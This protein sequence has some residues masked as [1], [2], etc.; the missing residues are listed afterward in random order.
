MS[1]GLKYEVGI[2]L[3]EIRNQLAYQKR[4]GFFFGAGSSCSVGISDIESL[5]EKIKSEL[6]SEHKTLF[7]STISTLKD[8]VESFGDNKVNIEDILNHIRL[9]RKITNENEES[10]F[11]KLTGKDAKYLDENICKAIYTII[12]EEEGKASLETPQ[13]FI[14]WLNWFSSDSTKEIFTSNYD[15]IFEKCLETQQVPYFDGFVGSYEPFFIQDSLDSELTSES[16]PKS[17]IRLWKVHGSI[18]WFWKDTNDGK[19]KKVIRRGVDSKD[20]LD[21]QEIVIYP[22]IDKYDSSR[23]QPFVVYLD[24]LKKFLGAGEGVFIISGYSFADQHINEIIFNG[25]RQN[26][27]LHAICFC[28][29]DE[30][31]EL[32]HK[33]SNSILNLT[34]LGPKSA[35]V[36]GLIFPSKNGHSFNSATYVIGVRYEKEQ[37]RKKTELF[38]RIQSQCC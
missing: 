21:G 6:S 7:V 8:Q 35:V 29:K 10:S 31:V 22:S 17:W 24:R 15:L 38:H 3:N 25:L 30:D 18:G 11:E 1:D 34:I 16:P 2:E 9:V 4:L 23:R 20:N 5:T 28:F 32:I 19:G 14:A 33:L 12:T 13:K 26:S 36:K 37:Q 27:R